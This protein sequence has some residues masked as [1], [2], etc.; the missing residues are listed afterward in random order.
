[1]PTELT[2]DQLLT[3]SQW[4]SPAFP[5][6]AFAYSHGLEAAVQGG[7]VQDAASFA[8]WLEGVLHHGAGRNDAVMIRLAAATV[9]PG[10]LDELNRAL[11]PSET[12]LLETEKMG[13]ALCQTIAAVWT[14][15]PQGLTY[16]VALGQAARATRMPLTPVV[17]MAL[18][19]FAANL[20]SA[21]IRLIPLGQTEGQKILQGMNPLC[22]DIAQQTEGATR[23]SLGTA[24]LVSDIHAMQHSTLYSR[25]FRS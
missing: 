21:A 5:V 25:M 17:Q 11:Q 1:M 10:P 4:M 15:M 8:G 24:P 3:L 2:S 23:H 19:S 16:P 14:E 12:R 20:V 18:H 7:A 13:D 22:L 6:G 9:D